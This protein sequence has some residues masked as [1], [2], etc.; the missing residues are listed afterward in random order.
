MLRTARTLDPHARRYTPL[1]G[2]SAPTTPKKKASAAPKSSTKASTKAAAKALSSSVR[3]TKKRAT[4][5][6]EPA[7]ELAAAEDSSDDD[8]VGAYGDEEMPPAT[9]HR[10]TGVRP[11]LEVA[12]TPA[13]STQP[14]LADVRFEPREHQPMRKEQYRV[15]DEVAWIP[16]A[17]PLPSA[18]PPSFAY[19]V[20]VD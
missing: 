9:P 20:L 17:R 14:L 2:A 5:K 13:P 19:N 8:E 7:E 12:H 16:Q 15:G 3:S 10:Y 6:V 18:T 11:L 1:V 4:R